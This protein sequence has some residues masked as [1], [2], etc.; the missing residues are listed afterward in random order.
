MKSKYIFLGALLTAGAVLS[1]SCSSDGAGAVYDS[2]SAASDGSAEVSEDGGAVK[3]SSDSS[4][5]TAISEA[6]AGAS[7]SPEVY[8][9]YGDALTG[10]RGNHILPDGRELEYLSSSGI[11]DENLFAIYDIDGDGRD[12]LIIKWT[13]ATEAGTVMYVYEYNV[14]ADAWT[15]EL[16]CFPT[17]CAY[18]NGVIL[19]DC[20]HNQGYAASIWPYDIYT[21]NENTDSYIAAGAVDC[22]NKVV[23]DQD[24]ADEPFPEEFDTDDAGVVYMINYAG[25]AGYSG[26]YIYSQSDYDEFE[27]SLTGDAGEVEI[28][29]LELTNANIDAATSGRG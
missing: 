17:V 29:Y 4:V 25:Y 26:G 21:Y 12:E 8:S 9:A 11:V 20:A 22:W 3:A 19:S 15:M 18:D 14:D 23:S 27:A 6:V 2:S 7:T 28:E 13:T 24:G 5:A 16:S 10:I 1:A